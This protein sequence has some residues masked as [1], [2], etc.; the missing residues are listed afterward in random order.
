MKELDQILRLWKEAEQSGESAVLATVVKTHGSSYRLPGARLLLAF[1]GRRAGSISG[2]CLEDDL[3]KKAYWLTERGPVIRRYDTTPDG[4]IGSGF[5]LGCSGVIHVLLERLTPGEPTVLNV[6]RD[7]RS[8]RRFAVIAHLIHP[9]PLTGQRL[10][11]DTL[12]TVSHN[13]GDAGL[14]GALERESKIGLSESA[15]RMVWVNNEVEAF[16]EMVS[17]GVRLLVFGAG[18]DAVPVT[19]LAKYLGWEV[20]VF[21]GRA[22]YAR[23]EKF[24]RADAVVVRLAGK[25]VAIPE[26]DPIAEIDK[27]TAAVLMSHSYSQDLEILHELAGTRLSYLGVLGPRKRTVQLLSDAGLDASLL[28]PTLHSPMGLDIG[29]DGPEQ[30]A[31]AVIAEIQ[32]ALNGRAGG[33]LRDRI[34]SIHSSGDASVDPEN[35]WLQPTCA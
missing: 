10:V 1:D 17:P 27:W 16:I 33:L 23:R 19:E 32:A 20:W 24:P 35:S 9:P 26:I 18:D 11:I 12:G 34:G 4:E 31:L 5:G 22:H 29:A 3:V 2:G 30:V 25:A 14:E 8:E 7:A 6:I 28:G 21:D 15:S 13:I